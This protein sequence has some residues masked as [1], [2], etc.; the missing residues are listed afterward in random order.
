MISKV[1]IKRFPDIW[2]DFRIALY[3]KYILKNFYVFEKNLTIY[4]KTNSSESSKF[5][6]FSKNWW[7]RRFQAHQYVKFFFKKYKIKYNKNLD[8]FLTFIVSKI[9]K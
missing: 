5:K 3:A 4:R 8:Y 1:E 9:I 6:K 2:I 7:K